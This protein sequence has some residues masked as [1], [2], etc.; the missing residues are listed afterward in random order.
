MKG[1]NEKSTVKIE[2]LCVIDRG[3]CE[4]S[5]RLSD[6]IHAANGSIQHGE[7]TKM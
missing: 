1:T 5:A 2:T 4:P 7:F 3:A 6:P